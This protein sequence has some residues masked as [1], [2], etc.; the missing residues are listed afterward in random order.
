M[1]DEKPTYE[2]LEARLAE[3]EA[4]IEVLRSQ[5]VDA[6]I[7]EEHVALVRLKELEE[8]LRVSEERLRS[9]FET[10]A[11]GVILIAPD[12]QIIQAN[13]AAERILGLQRSEIETRNY[14]APEWAILCPDGTPMP[15]EEM[16]GPRAMKEKRPV[17][18]VVMGVV[19]PDG[20]ISW[21]NVS[22]API[23]DEAGELEG[24]VGTFADI[25]ERKQAEELLELER[26]RLSM[27][28]ETF[29]GY[30]YLQSPD[31]S[32]RYANRYFVEHFGEPK[33][34]LCY[35][36]LWGR[37]EPCEVCPT[38]EVFDT[39]TPQVWEWSQTPDGRIYFIYDHPFIDS[40]GSELVLEI[41]VD[42]TDRK[43]A[44][45]A[46]KLRVEQ[47]AAL[48]QASQVVTASLELDQVLAEIVSLAGR[49]VSSDYTSVVLVDEA[50]NTSQSAEN[51]PGV[52]GIEYRIRDKGLTRWIVRSRQPAIIDEIGEDGAMTPDLGEGA[53][54][55]VNPPIVEAGVKSVAGLPLMVKD[56]LLGVLYLHSLHPGAFH[57][58]LPLLTT[59]ANQAAIA[60]EN[61]RLYQ[62]TQRE[63]A[64]RK[65]A[66]EELRQSYV[67]LQ[68]ALEGTV[69][70]LASAVEIRDPYTA[71]HQRRVTQ[72]ACAIA[73]EIG[74]PEEQ[75]EGL[76]MAGL[77]HD[78]GK[79]SVPA[80]V[81]SK[82]GRLHDI[83][84]GLIKAHPQ[85]GHDIL[86]DLDFPWPLAHIV[87]QHHERLDGSGYPQGL[88]DGEIMLEARILAVA[89]V[90]EAMASHRPYRPAHSIENALE[91]IS[92]NRGVLYDAEVVD[93]C[94]KLFTE[95]GFTFE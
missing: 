81:L 19:R 65:R 23:I 56:R 4:V 74:L 37:K 43:W 44:E 53:P 62:E 39:K 94:L 36:V 67:N 58:Q 66:Q 90:V 89:D 28:L 46:L 26:K 92:Q 87:L 93:A 57:G 72:L 41:G 68:K 78:L 82:P 61:A 27:L 9:L 8:A 50:G 48:S 54:R 18:D 25:T 59:F 21:I 30:I 13:P 76:R 75:I 29:P 80:E 42:I 49:V 91:E 71:G 45:E 63:L 69:H 3:A 33:E 86:K 1:S 6:I 14:I 17:K 22:A 95:D 77:I 24:A 32:V 52:P 16:A 64:E 84:Y 40:D 55:F 5:Q 15:P 12:G 47:L 79:I 70:A 85:I 20:S 7:G 51:L 31:Y 83:E 34:R 11:E 10:M 38:F 35:E 2:E 60:V 73:N 88:S